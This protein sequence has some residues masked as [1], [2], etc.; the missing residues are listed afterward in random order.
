MTSEEYYI[1]D[2]PNPLPGSLA[3][4]LPT[5]QAERF[6]SLVIKRRFDRFIV[7]AILSD[8]IPLS[9]KLPELLTDTSSSLLYVNGE[10]LTL[11]LEYPQYFPLMYELRAGSEKELLHIDFLIDTNHPVAA[12]APAR[13]AVNQLLDVLMRHVWLPLVIIRLDVYLKDEPDVLLH[14]LIMPFTDRLSIGPLGGFGSFAPLAPYE[15]LLR[16]AI[17]AASPYYRFL[18][19]YRVLEGVKYLRSVMAKIVARFGVQERMPRPPEVDANTILGLGLGE[20]FADVKNIDGLVGRF[21]KPRDN[22]SHFL[23]RDQKQPLHISD[24]TNYRFYSCGAAI[25]LFYAHASVRDLMVY[26]NQH[27]YGHFARGTKAIF[28]ED[29]DLLVLKFDAYTGKFGQIEDEEDDMSRPMFV[30]VVEGR[31]VEFINISHVVRVEVVHPAEGQSGS[32]TIHLQDG[33]TRQLGESEINFVMR[34]FQ[35]LVGEPVAG[36][37]DAAPGYWTGSER[38]TEAKAGR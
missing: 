9:G 24:G 32:G 4:L 26:F 7:R 20:S 6:N 12:L 33:T 1:C 2:P 17:G 29:K 27:L 5:S 11:H 36:T 34:V 16:E 28:P 37:Q 10:P 23:L 14:Q 21:T 15:A 25:L 18:C 38:E 30:K 19:A 13:T 3:V 31:K 8:N 35:G 22:L